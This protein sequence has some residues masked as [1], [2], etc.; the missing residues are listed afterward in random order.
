VIAEGVNAMRSE[1]R[2]ILMVTHYQRLLD[3]IKPD[4]IHVLANG[5]IIKSGDSSLA[6]MLEEKGYSW[7]DKEMES[8][9]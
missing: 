1:A 4:F 9:V 5:K 8:K 6:L 2:S 7:I 3:Y